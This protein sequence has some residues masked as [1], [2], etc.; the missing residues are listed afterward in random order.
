M[1]N[2]IQMKKIAIETGAKTIG[3]AVSLSV[4]AKLNGVGSIQRQAISGII[5]SA[6]EGVIKDSQKQKQQEK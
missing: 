2:Q 5:G 1:E 4:D 3:S 6:V